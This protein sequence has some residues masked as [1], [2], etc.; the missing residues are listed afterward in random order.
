[1]TPSDQIPEGGEGMTV[2]QVAQMFVD[3]SDIPSLVFLERYPF[4]ERDRAAFAEE[5]RVSEDLITTTY[6]RSLFRSALGRGDQQ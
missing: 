4:Y 2:E 6:F 1:M 3:F 5:R